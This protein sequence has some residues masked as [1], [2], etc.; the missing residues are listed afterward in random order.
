MTSS[1]GFVIRA[2]IMRADDEHRKRRFIRR[3]V[4]KPAAGLAQGCG[5]SA[6]IVVIKPWIKG[7]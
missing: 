6:G 2:D 1:R 5:E 7:V 4:A 3:E